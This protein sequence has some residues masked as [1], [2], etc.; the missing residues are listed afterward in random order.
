MEDV[1]AEDDVLSAPASVD[2]IGEIG[3]TGSGDGTETVT[4]ARPRSVATRIQDREKPDYVALLDGA[5]AGDRRC[6]DELLVQL[7]PLVRS[8]VGR[9]RLDP[10]SAADVVQTVWIRLFE[11]AALIRDPS[12][13]PGWLS[14]TGRNESVNRINQLRRLGPTHSIEDQAEPGLAPDQLFIEDEARR[15]VRRAFHA[16]PRE[17]RTLLALSFH[18]PRLSYAEIAERIG[19]PVGSIG[20]TRA[21]YLSLLREQLQLIGRDGSP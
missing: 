1:T 13:L 3:Q 9:Y 17:A 4:G 2:T 11:N 6:W 7:N 8:V 19:R 20:P 16:L 21:R 15:D 10:E 5:I 18:R 14:A 12:R